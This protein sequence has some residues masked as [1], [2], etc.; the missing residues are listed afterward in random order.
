MDMQFLLFVL[1][2]FPSLYL[3]QSG[4]AVTNWPLNCMELAE[5]VLI[6]SIFGHVLESI[7]N[8]QKTYTQATN[9][10]TQN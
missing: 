7:K 3:Y 8:K 10:A 2:W 4:K 6:V 9:K 5:A 1:L